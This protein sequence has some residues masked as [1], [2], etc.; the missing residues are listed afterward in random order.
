MSGSTC[1]SY[2]NIA[3]SEDKVLTT[4]VARIKTDEQRPSNKQNKSGKKVIKWKAFLLQFQA[5]AIQ[6]NGAQMLA[7]GTTVK[8][9]SAKRNVYHTHCNFDMY[10][11]D[12]THQQT[13]NGAIEFIAIVTDDELDA[14]FNLIDIEHCDNFTLQAYVAYQ[15]QRQSKLSH[16]FDPRT[17]IPKDAFLSTTR[18]F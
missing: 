2:L 8:A 14:Y 12:S 15:R 13:D 3:I 1:I 6:L 4:E 5:A 18:E 9:Q 11:S 7:R 17:M 10:H 16:S